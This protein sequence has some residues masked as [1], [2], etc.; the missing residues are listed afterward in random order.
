MAPEVLAGL[1]ASE[2][3][4]VYSV[5][6]LL[7]HLV[8]AAYPV[9]GRSLDELRAA[10]MQGQRRPASEHRAGLPRPFIRVLDRALAADPQRRHPSADALGEALGGLSQKA[11]AL[12]AVRLVLTRDAR[13]AASSWACSD[14]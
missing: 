13:A 14:F 5:G 6:V 2:S 7:Y 11:R 4:D 9:E 8:T 12:R 10:H 1:P 3:S